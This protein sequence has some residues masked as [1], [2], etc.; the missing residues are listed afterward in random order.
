MNIEGAPSEGEILAAKQGARM[1]VR[2]WRRRCVNSLIGLLLNCAA[3]VPFSAG[4]PLYAHFELG[5]ILIQ[6]SMVL[7][8][9]AAYFGAAWWES[10]SNLRY[11]EKIYPSPTE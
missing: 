5:K 1:R 11:L 4:E 10:W 8:I 3:V 2:F 7:L 6:L 9:V